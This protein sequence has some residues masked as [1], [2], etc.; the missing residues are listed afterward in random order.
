MGA[1]RPLSWAGI[2]RLG[3]A[4]VGLGAV[5]VLTTSTLNRLMVVELALPAM[6][7]GLLVGLHYAMGMLRPRWGH[8]SDRGRRTPWILGGMAALATGGFLAACATVLME[9]AFWPGVALAT[10]AFTLIGGGVGAAGTAVLALLA[11]RCAPERRAP[12]ATIVWLMMIVGLGATAGISGAFLDPYSPARLVTVAGCVALAAMTLATLGVIGMERGAAPSA[13]A[14]QTPFMDVLRETLAEPAARRFTVFVFVSMLAFSAQDLILEPFAGHVFGF[15]VGEST[16]LAA[17]QQ[18]GIFFGMVLTA[19][20]A[21]AA[22]RR[23]LGE[24]AGR[25]SFWIVAGCLGSGL[26]LAGL[27]A[28]AFTPGWP[29]AVNVFA[30]GFMNGMFAVA[31]IASMMALAG[32]TGAGREG[33]RMGLWGASQAIAFG[34]GGLLGATLVDIAR[35]L[36]GEPS[37]AYAAVFALEATLFMVAAWL[38]ASVGVERAGAPRGRADYRNDAPAAALVAGE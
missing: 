29:L 30:L 3:L 33:A 32:A 13:E 28:G 12:A 25:L 23:L 4:Q 7:P 8:G 26:A 16:T 35:A 5:V 10:F 34:L 24:A 14:A 27:V 15:T 9:T 37:L 36:V 19:V 38:G 17:K 6:L 21:S 1:L 31:A 11:T 20:A 22:G 18:S 2:F